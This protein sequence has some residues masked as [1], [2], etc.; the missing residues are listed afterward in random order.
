MRYREMAA[1]EAGRIAELDA[2]CYIRRAWRRDGAQYRLTEIGWTEPGLPNGLAWHLARFAG[3]VDGGGKAFG[4]FAGGRLIGYAVA[5]PDRFGEN[6]NYL[7]LDQ[8]FVSRGERRKGIGTELFRLCA[9]YAASVGANR[10]FLCSA[11]SEDTVEFYRS[12]GCVRAAEV[13]ARLH[14]DARDIP[15][16]YDVTR[17]PGC[18]GTPLDRLF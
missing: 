14:E 6:A 15:L 8:M 16:E 5:G 18:A 3:A 7:L 13:D 9:E 4:C 17:A 12:L 1:A 2:G 11:S 10:L